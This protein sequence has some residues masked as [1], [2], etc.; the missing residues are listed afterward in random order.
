MIYRQQKEIRWHIAQII[1]RLSLTKKETK[2]I[3]FNDI[4]QW[5]DDRGIIANGDSKTQFVKLMEEGGELAQAL[6][7]NDKKEIKNNLSFRV[8]H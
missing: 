5:A 3:T 1:P 2:H 4:R 6:L 8:S 7:K